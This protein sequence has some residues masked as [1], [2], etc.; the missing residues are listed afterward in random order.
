MSEFNQQISSSQNSSS[1]E[2]KLQNVRAK[3]SDVNGSVRKLESNMIFLLV[4]PQLVTFTSQGS[5]EQ[6]DPHT[7][8]VDTQGT[9]MMSNPQTD[10]GQEEFLT[11]Q[12]ELNGQYAENMG[13]RHDLM[14]TKDEILD[15]LYEQKKKI[16]NYSSD[17][18]DRNNNEHP[19]L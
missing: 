10:Y 15:A 14:V 12:T 19:L 2:A 1:L 9:V 11:N 4:H 3:L 17:S 8:N 5:D 16:P 13:L 18:V 6:Q 7:W